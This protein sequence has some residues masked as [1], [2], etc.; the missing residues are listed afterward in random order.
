MNTRPRPPN[1]AAR[2][3]WSAHPRGETKAA[4]RG[5]KGTAP[6]GPHLPPPGGGHV[7]ERLLQP[8]DS[9]PRKCVRKCTALVKRPLQ[10]TKPGRGKRASHFD[11]EWGRGEA[12][13]LCL[14][15]RRL[16]PQLSTLSRAV[17]SQQTTSARP[18]PRV[19]ISARLPTSLPLPPPQRPGGSREL[20]TGSLGCTLSTTSEK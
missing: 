19:G 16:S 8:P 3:S 4:T 5:F 17:L 14:K 18:V 11:R 12:N 6:R 7:T 2:A 1:P 9:G 20:G 13:A 15:I 10:P